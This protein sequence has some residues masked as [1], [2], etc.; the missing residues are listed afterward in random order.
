MLQFNLYYLQ[1]LSLATSIAIVWPHTFFSVKKIYSSL[2]FSYFEIFFFFVVKTLLIGS[3]MPF[4]SLFFSIPTRK[5]Y[6]Q[7]TMLCLQS[8][9]GYFM[10]L[11]AELTAWNLD[12][13]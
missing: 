2:Q 12:E 3:V 13:S 6:S 9:F 5:V 1:I 8:V 7:D 11:T 10:M 4:N